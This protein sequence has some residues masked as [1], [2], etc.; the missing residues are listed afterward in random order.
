MVNVVFSRLDNKCAYVI[1]QMVEYSVILKLRITVSPFSRT[2]VENP[3]TGF[4]KILFSRATE[5]LAHS[6]ENDMHKKH[7]PPAN[8]HGSHF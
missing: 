7:Y 4:V 3:K 2:L 1:T 5:V 8:H 6:D